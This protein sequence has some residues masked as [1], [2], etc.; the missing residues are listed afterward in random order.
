MSLSRL[1]RLINFHPPSFIIIPRIIAGGDYSR[2]Q[3]DCSREAKIQHFGSRVLLF[4]YPIKSKNDHIRKTEHG[5]F[6]CSKFGSLIN[7]QCQ[8]LRYQNLIEL[9]LI[10]LLDQTPLQV[11]REGIRERED[12]ERG[13]EWAYIRGRRLSS[14]FPSKRGN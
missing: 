5:L 13:R 12:G 1:P 3:G 10:I 8:Y 14:I 7:F 11:D 2:R 6:K 4:Y 9:S